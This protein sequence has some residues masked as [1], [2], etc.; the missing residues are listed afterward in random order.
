MTAEMQTEG[1][2]NVVPLRRAQAAPQR[3][4]RRRP[5]RPRRSFGALRELPSG[6]FQAYY[7]L[8]GKRF[9]APTTF[10]SRGDASA[11][12]AM[13]EAEFVEHRWKPAPP[14]DP[15]K[16]RFADYAETWLAGRDLSP[17]TASHYRGTLRGRLGR[18]SPEGRFCI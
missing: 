9:L 7:T 8:E 1:F 4:G 13:R 3:S 6:R 12:L 14:P 15:T 2:S 5:R 17:K 11:W 16:V 18:R 10:F